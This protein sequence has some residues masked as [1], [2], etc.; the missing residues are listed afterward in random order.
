MKTAPEKAALLAA[1]AEA[2]VARILLDELRAGRTSNALELLE[3]QLDTNLLILERQLKNAEEAERSQ[4]SAVLKIIQD[5]R[6]RYPRK[7]AASIRE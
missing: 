5:Y 6:A 7:N 3:Q 1:Q 4:I 2:L